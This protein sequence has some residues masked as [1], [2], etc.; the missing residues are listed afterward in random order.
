MRHLVEA[1][2]AGRN[3]L[4]LTFYKPNICLTARNNH[5]NTTKLD[6]ASS[7]RIAHVKQQVETN[8]VPSLTVF[9][10]N[11][12]GEANPNQDFEVISEQLIKKSGR[13]LL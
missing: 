6:E 10:R 1:K 2:R 12:G 8:S 11:R 7:I 13:N 4:E 3:L 5:Q 9:R